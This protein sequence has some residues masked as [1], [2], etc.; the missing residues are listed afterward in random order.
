[1]DGHDLI[2]LGQHWREVL[3]HALFVAPHAPVPCAVNPAGFE[4][5]PLALDENRRLDAEDFAGLEGTA[6]ARPVI[7][8]FLEALWRETGLG[9]EAT[10]LAGFSQGAMMALD[11]GLRLDPPPL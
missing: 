8:A 7:M 10:I 6:A 2:A 5:F 1:S 4:W 11:T 3:P 9:P